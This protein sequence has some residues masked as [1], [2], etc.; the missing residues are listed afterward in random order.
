M[1]GAAGIAAVILAAGTSTRMGWF[2]PM[3]P[4]GDA[5]ALERVV[6]TFRAGGVE[7]LIVITGH[8]AGELQ[9]VLAELPAQAVVNTA[10]RQG[11]FSS[12]RAGLNALPNDAEAFFIHP[13]DI[14]LVRSRTVERM[15]A[16][17]TETR[18]LV[19]YPT[20]E[21]RR[22]HPTLIR[23]DLVPDTL[24]WHGEGGLRAFL[25]GRAAGSRELPVADEAVLLDMDTVEDYRRLVARLRHA[26]L[27]SQAEC[28]ML[29]DTLQALPG[30]L[31]A[32]CRAVAAVARRLAEA[33][34]AAGTPM[35]VVL[36]ERAAL[37]H[38]IARTRKDHAAAGA[39]LLERHGFPRLAPI[40]AEHMDLAVAPDTLPDE[41]QV[42][43]LADKLVAGD[44]LVDLEERFARKMA[45]YGRDPSV[46]PRI[47]QRRDNARRARDKVERL[48]GRSVNAMAAEASRI[49]SP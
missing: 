5:C 45:Q 3:L 28:R 38:D 4:L 32:H 19:L 16:A 43:F 17:F 25:Q 1:S 40:V 20:F 2:K 49:S 34:E 36:A 30:P 39:R 26:D 8:R 47:A 23:R 6:R 27:P 48:T 13:V 42:V 15:A 37:L 18:P 12:V 9:P 35:D 21:G 29:M 14:P 11:M 7:T 31:A 33:L 46:G 44:R 10:Y 24:A 22:G 41:A